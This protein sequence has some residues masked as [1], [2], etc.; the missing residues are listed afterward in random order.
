MRRRVES[1]IVSGD[2]GQYVTVA[3]LLSAAQPAAG[4]AAA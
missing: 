3:W 2:Q 4:A 1:R